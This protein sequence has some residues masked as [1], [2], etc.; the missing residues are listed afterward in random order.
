M[1]KGG[2]TKEVREIENQ[3]GTQSIVAASEGGGRKPNP[4]KAVGH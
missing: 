4:R 1:G 3:R 2:E